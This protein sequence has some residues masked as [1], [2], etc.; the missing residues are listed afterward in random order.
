M[1]RKNRAMTQ[2]VASSDPMADLARMAEKAR[3]QRQVLHNRALRKWQGQIDRDAWRRQ[4]RADKRLT[5]LVRYCLR[6]ALSIAVVIGMI[7]IELCQGQ[8][9]SKL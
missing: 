7:S 8:D 1:A 9:G 3:L 4:Q 2:R 5:D 6:I